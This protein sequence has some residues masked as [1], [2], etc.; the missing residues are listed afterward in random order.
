VG[1]GVMCSGKY[2]VCDVTLSVHP[3]RASWKVCLTR[4]ESN[5]RP[6]GN[7]PNARLAEYW[8]GIPKLADAIHMHRY[9]ASF[10]ACSVWVHT[11]SKIKNIIHQLVKQVFQFWL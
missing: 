2:E 5:P 3:H 6:L 4:W 7:P 9:Q 11:Q 1:V 10:S 8:T